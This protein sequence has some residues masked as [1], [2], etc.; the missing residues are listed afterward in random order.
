MTERHFPLPAPVPWQPAPEFEQLRREEPIAQVTLPTGNTAWLVTRYE[1]NRAMLADARFS[2]AAAAG[3][4]APR[5]RLVPLER[6]A[7][8][9]LDP[10][11][12]TRLRR[13]VAQAFTMRRIA[14]LQPW[15]E[16]T[17]SDLVTKAA[18]AGPPIDL[19]ASLTRPLPITVIC[20]LLGVPPSDQ[21]RFRSWSETYL[22][23]TGRTASEITEAAES[24]RAYLA[25]LV[26]AHR[27][28]PADDLLSALVAAQDEERLTEDE[29][30]TFG[31]TLLVAGFE[32]AA[33]QIAGALF[34]LLRHP[35]ELARL[36]DHPEIGPTAVEE[37][38][39]YTP[40]AAAGGV[41]RVAVAPVEL[42]GVTIQAGEA[43]LPAL[44]SANRDEAVF[45]EPDRLDLTRGHNPHLTF[46]HGPHH[47]LGAQLA[48][49]EL[50]SAVGAVVRLL[51]G[52]KLAVPETDI[53]WDSAKLLRGPRALPVTW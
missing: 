13:L 50:T 35:D 34:A 53:E 44:V 19:V 11:E 27:A 12:H 18:A 40:S 4:G 14:G 42:G 30:I 43:V 15:I 17:A 10:P 16:Q 48:R 25:D 22:S 31:V 36:R 24:L 29:L 1:E 47:C 41:I 32:T 28:E 38:L 20:A 8:T 5:A 51:P 52:V 21:E 46:G 7:L 2:R 49:A 37:L 6:G 39:R 33:N 45:E 3:P 23:L 9:T 26:A